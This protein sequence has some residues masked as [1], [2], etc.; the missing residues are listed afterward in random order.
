MWRAAEHSQNGHAGTGETKA[1]AQVGTG[2]ST[3]GK[4]EFGQ[5]RQTAGR[6]S[7]VDTCQIWQ[8]FRKNLA[9]TGSI[10]TKEAADL[11]QKSKALSNAG[12]ILEGTLIPAMH[13]GGRFSTE[14]TR[15]FGCVHRKRK[16]DES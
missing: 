1:A 7:C 9:G 6:A 4:A 14:W 12:E 13:T 11:H 5:G 15:R 3:E 10:G 2:S 16:D 8:A